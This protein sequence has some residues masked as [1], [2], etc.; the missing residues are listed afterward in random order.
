ML[1]LLA[2]SCGLVTVTRR[3]HQLSA[4]CAGD[5]SRGFGISSA[6]LLEFRFLPAEKQQSCSS[7]NFPPEKEASKQKKVRASLG[8]HGGN[9][10]GDE[11]A[12]T[13]TLS[14]LCELWR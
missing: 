8:V 2:N 11:E 4:L 3:V 6:A 5:E 1:S 12:A 10:S 9:E 14:L 13:T 7:E